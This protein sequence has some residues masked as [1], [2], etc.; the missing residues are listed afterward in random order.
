MLISTDAQPLCIWISTPADE[1]AKAWL[2]LYVVLCQF[3]WH[4]V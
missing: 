1:T 4:V 3:E 2:T